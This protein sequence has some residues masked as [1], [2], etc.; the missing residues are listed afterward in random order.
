[1]LIQKQKDI[2]TINNKKTKYMN[3]EKLN[4]KNWILLQHKT[5][6]YIGIIIEVNMSFITIISYRDEVKSFKRKEIKV[7]NY[8]PNLRIVPI[9]QIIKENPAANQQTTKIVETIKKQKN[10]D[11]ILT[12][13][14][15]FT[16]KDKKQQ[17]N[18][19]QKTT[20]WKKLYNWIDEPKKKSKLA[21]ILF[22]KHQDLEFVVV[23][24]KLGKIKFLN[25]NFQEIMKFS[26]KNLNILLKKF[27][28]ENEKKD[29]KQHGL[30]DAFGP[31]GIDETFLESIKKEA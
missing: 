12:N 28:K 21:P 6:H 16:K 20:L 9:K 3:K 24:T 2:Y 29:K 27:Q 19:I 25:K 10:Y 14:L 4:S 5:K 17:I 1:V 11:L 31:L 7:I 22:F 23:V 18:K 15:R 13:N 26:N 30:K 8:K